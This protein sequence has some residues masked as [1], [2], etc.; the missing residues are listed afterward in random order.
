M[1][2][3]EKTMIDRIDERLVTLGKT[4]RAASM[5]ATGKPDLIR[6]LRAGRT[7]H[8]RSDTIKALA[9]V[10]ETTPDFL[11]GTSPAPE[12]PAPIFV[13]RHGAADLPVFG[14]AAGSVLGALTMGTEPVE[15]VPCPTGLS[16]VKGAYALIVTG[17]SME[18]RYMA[19]DMIFLHPHRPPRPGDHVVIQE[20]SDGT[21]TWIKRFE[22]QTE[23]HLVT[24]QYNPPAEV[25]FARNTI[26]AVHRV[27]TTNELF[28]I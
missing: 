28:G 13:E 14:L 6:T 25:K 15:Y 18:P 22:R 3:M 20:I 21:K 10:L 26:T 7:R 8:P 16:R 11:L 4:D 24:L 12:R 17:S 1:P 23:T 9:D 19:G 27:L 5:E 2:H